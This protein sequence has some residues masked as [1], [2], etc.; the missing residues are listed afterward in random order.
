MPQPVS[1]NP[2]TPVSGSIQ[3]NN[4]SYVVDGQ[5]RNYR[6]GFGGLSWMSEVPA[7]NN[8]IFIGNSVS[9]GRGPANIPLFYPSYNNSAANI[10]YAANT[11]PGSPRNFTT[12]GSAY[13]WATTNNFFINNSNN[14][15]PKINADGLVLYV[16]ANQPTSYP[17]T[18]TSWYDMSGRNNNGTLINGPTWNSNGWIVFDSTDD[19]TDT[20]L[21]TNTLF[22]SNDPFSISITLKPTETI[23]AL[24]GLVC[25]QRYQS[26]DFPGGFGLVT[27]NDNQV[28]IN[29]TKNDGTGTVSYQ[30]LAPTTLTINSWQNIIYTYNPNTGT[31]IGYKN[32]TVDNSSTSTSYKWTP[33]AR[34]TW[35]A[36]NTQGGWGD[37]FSSEISNVSIY[38]KTLTESEIKQNYFQAPI[39]T[40]GLVL[41]V[42]ANNLVSYP[43][44]GTTAY[45]LTSSIN[46]TLI[47]GTSFNSSYGGYWA[48]DGVDDYISWGNNFNLTSTS[49]SGFV[50]GW[51]NSLNDYLPWIDK[52]S[53]NGNYRFH[54]DSIGRLIFGIRNTANAYEQML[55]G[56]LVLTNTWYHLG[57]TFNNSTREGKIYVNGQL[58]SSYTFTIDRGDTTTDLQTGYQA[59]NGGTLNGRIASLSL[60]NKALTSDEVQQNYQAT[61]DKFLGQNIVTNGLTLY[62]DSANKDSYP[63]TGTTW[64]DL[65]GNGYNGTL[66]NG[67][68]FLSNQNGGILDFDGVDDYTSLGSSAA[69][70]IQGKTAV[71]IG[72][73]FKLDVLDDLRGLIGTLNYFCGGNLGLVARGDV[74]TFYNDTGT[75]YDVG[76]SSFVETGKWIY[77]VG[78][79]DGTTTRIYGIKD[80]TLSQSSGTSK[81]GATNT[82]TSD[83]IVIGNQYSSYFTNGQCGT[84]F[85]Y[86]RVLS[87]EEILQNYNATKTRFGL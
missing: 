14:P 21:A 35:I 74:L 20:A 83:F 37:F 42:D 4:I 43:K 2:G 69:S 25:N 31:V 63:G 79:Y 82:F 54:A 71:T 36:R 46:G 41:A 1:Y 60:Y 68:S 32:G 10:I 86:N 51:A 39:V 28:A 80:G 29:L 40:D 58:Q 11:L 72:I 8:V 19:Y 17:Q 30:A 16:D 5:N 7:A 13:D 33:E 84:A 3:E 76:I 45:P 49:I 24:S 12:T 70:L 15:I 34:T 27:Y 47:N 85:V 55:T 50:W 38:K 57:F 23:N 65:S 62:L 52:L 66:T 59:N 78:T 56:V 77:A 26:E 73:F 61:K 9:L 6:G 48:F 44:S 81:S 53:S 75:C 87:Q 22:S 64:Y 67:P 18:G